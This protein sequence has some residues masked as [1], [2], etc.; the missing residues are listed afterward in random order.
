[1]AGD[2]ALRAHLDV[3]LERL[4]GPAV[5]LDRV[6]REQLIAFV[7]LLEKWNRVHNL[8]AVRDARDMIGRHV[9]DSLA[10]LPFVGE[11]T[12]D[13]VEVAGVDAIPARS[14]ATVDLLDVGSGGGLPVL[15]LAIALPQLRCLSVESNNKKVRFQRQ[16]VLE[17]GLASVNVRHARI[18]DVSVCARQVVSRAF[19]APADFLSIAARLCAPG[20]AAIVMLG[21]AERLP[22]LLPEPFSCEALKA[23]TVPFTDGVRHVAICRARA[24][25]AARP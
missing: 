13:E 14:S 9:L 7:R 2:H 22:E 17:L 16:A 23:L 19:T 4:G 21:H 18:E 20:G 8:T 11:P 15:P 24:A 12:R 10:L 3:G 1:M 6:S 5:E 25:T